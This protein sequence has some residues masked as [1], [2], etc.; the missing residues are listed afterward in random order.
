[1]WHC[2]N[3]VYTIQP[4]NWIERNVVK[5][6]VNVM[7]VTGVNSCELNWRFKNVAHKQVRMIYVKIDE[8]FLKRWY[9][10][11]LICA[12]RVF[13]PRHRSA[14]SR[15]LTSQNVEGAERKRVNKR[16]RGRSLLNKTSSR[17]GAELDWRNKIAESRNEN[18]PSLRISCLSILYVPVAALVLVHTRILV[19]LLQVL[20]F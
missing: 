16:E 9:V 15:I 7:M 11:W 4:I 8:S 20:L 3:G 17:G 6:L 14:K 19:P 1:M 18:T 12:V 13:A 2:P 5:Q 10:W